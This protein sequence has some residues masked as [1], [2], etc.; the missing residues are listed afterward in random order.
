[1]ADVLNRTTLEL[2]QS[3]HTPDFDPADWLIAP[4]L[5]AVA[6]VAPRYWKLEGDSVVPMTRVERDA[7]DAQ[8]LADAK[9]QRR[10][11]LRQQA[12]EVGRDELIDLT[13]TAK[14]RLAT[15]LASVE[16]ATSIEDVKAAKVE[17]ARAGVR[18]AGAIRL[19]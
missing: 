3:V 12:V 19:P 13:S 2:R 6:E 15:A 4:D 11:L 8:R 18:D 7:V 10:E 16:T 9:T 17:G 5:S 14:T 1:M